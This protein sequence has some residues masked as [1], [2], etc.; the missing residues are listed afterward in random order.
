MFTWVCPQCGRDVPPSYN[1]CPDCSAKTA[2]AAPPPG[3]AAPPQAPLDPAQPPPYSPPGPPP[4][5]HPTSPLFQAPPQQQAPQ[6]PPQPQYGQQPQYPPQQPQYAQQPQYPQQPP[7]YAQQQYP[8]QQYG[9]PPQY[10][11]PPRAK[12]QLPT[13]LLAVLFAFA[14][15][16]VGLGAVWLFTGGSSKHIAVIETPPSKDSPAQKYIEVTGL[17]FTG[18]SRGL[19]VSFIVINHSD[20]DLLNLAGT[21]KVYGVT[22]KKEEDPVGTFTFQ[23]AMAAEQSKELQMPFT[24]KMKLVDLPDW[25]LVKVEVQITSP[26]GA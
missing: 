15:V 10:P 5:Y 21:V 7:Q 25:Q 12:F 11:P 6:Y 14:I 4:V 22:Q 18:A 24:T 23:T 2:G 1:E 8:P 17:R 3:S 19:V 16:G 9:Q 13:W 26:P 20:S